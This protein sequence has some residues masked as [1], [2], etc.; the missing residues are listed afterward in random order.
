MTISGIRQLNQFQYATSVDKEKGAK[1]NVDASLKNHKEFVETA[2]KQNLAEI[3]KN[4]EARET[5]STWTLIGAIVLGPFIGSAIGGAIGGAA[6]DG[7]EAAGREL[8]K[9][10]SIS[11]MGAERAMDAFGEARSRLEET[12]SDRQGLEK[13]GAELRDASWSGIT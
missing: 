2:Y 5:Q 4:K 12:K 3:E 9:Q 13:F 11:D 1:E 7:D 8:K 10:G 6:N